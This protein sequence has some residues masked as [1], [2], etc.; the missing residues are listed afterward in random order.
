MDKYNKINKKEALALAKADEHDAFE[1][2]Y[3]AN[4]IKQH[5]KADKIDL[6]SIVSAKTGGCTED[7]SFCAQSRISSA[8]I[9]KHSLVSQ[10]EVLQSAFSAQ[11]HGAQRFCIV[12]SGRATSKSDLKKISKMITL[13]SQTGLY[14]CATLGLLRSDELSSL[15]EAGLVRYHH[16]LETSEDFFTHICSTHTY[17]DKVKTIMAAQK[18]GLSV[19]SGGIFGLGETWEDRI[20]MAF[21]LKE[22]NVDSVPINF[23]SPISGT[24]LGERQCLKPLEALKIIALYRLIM[25]DKEIRVCGGRP[26]TLRQLNSLVFFAGANALLIGNYLT[27]TGIE[28]QE[29]IQ[30]IKDLGFNFYFKP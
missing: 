3:H 17:K 11:A 26:R 13:I 22:L 27:T 21:A 24:P 4:R 20:E 10:E 25:P 2:F 5:Y 28:P 16:N 15:K 1:L 7:C 30:L 29:D 18:T 6:C 23:L 12:T 14:P 19:C 8:T 9:K